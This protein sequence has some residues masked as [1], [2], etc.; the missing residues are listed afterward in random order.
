M[1]RLVNKREDSFQDGR[2][3]YE[4]GNYSMEV[5]LVSEAG[6]ISYC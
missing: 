2:Q 6:D 4:E 3:V 5:K 1:G